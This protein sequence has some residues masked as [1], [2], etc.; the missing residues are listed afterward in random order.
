MK[1]CSF[2]LVFLLSLTGLYSES[3]SFSWRFGFFSVVGDDYETLPFACVAQMKDGERS[4][5]LV[6]SE[7]YAWN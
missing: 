5:L 1:K 2:I 4:R 6:S 3:N 7:A